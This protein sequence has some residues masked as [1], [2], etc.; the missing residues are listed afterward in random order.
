MSEDKQIEIRKA[1]SHFVH[2]LRR[3]QLKKS[4]RRKTHERYLKQ[5]KGPNAKTN[6]ERIINNW[7]PANTLYLIGCKESDFHL[8]KLKL[9][10]PKNNGV[11]RVPKDFSLI[12]HPKESY[13]LLQQLT[14]AFINQSFPHFKIDYSECKNL[15]LG[16]QVFLDIIIK[17]IITFYNRCA[18]YNN[19]RS[20]VKSIAG[21]NVRDPNIAKLLFSVGSPAIHMNKTINYP[22]IIP[23]KLCIHNREQDGDPVKIREQKDLDTTA[24]VD[25]V[26]ECLKRMNKTLTQDKLYDL[27]TAI[28]EILINAEEHSTTK[29]RFSIGYFHE[30]KENGNHF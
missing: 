17:D 12:D 5:I 22:D 19:T 2:D 27:C 24:L 3:R 11:F 4:K 14:A 21:I 10:I 20:R 25:Y 26:L 6:R 1:E 9:N 13:K 23:Y 7:L 8:N 28:G 15:D 29:Y 16:A 30:L 18:Q